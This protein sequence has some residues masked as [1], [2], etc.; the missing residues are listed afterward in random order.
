ML[1]VQDSISSVIHYSFR[2][3]MGHVHGSKEKCNNNMVGMLT[4]SNG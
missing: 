1:Y 4:S 3:S 2:I